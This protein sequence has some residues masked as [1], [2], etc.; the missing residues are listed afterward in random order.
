MILH[1]TVHRCGVFW[2]SAFISNSVLTFLLTAVPA[3]I[4]IFI[5]AN[6]A[7]FYHNKYTFPFL[8][9][10]MRKKGEIVRC[11]LLG[12]EKFRTL[13]P[14]KNVNLN[15]NFKIGGKGICKKKNLPDRP[16]HK[17]NSEKKLQD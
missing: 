11:I 1:L 15:K 4:S 16:L 5:Q 6:H 2:L 10:N 12:K 8:A 17:S 9:Q 3:Y 7:K 13:P 14:K